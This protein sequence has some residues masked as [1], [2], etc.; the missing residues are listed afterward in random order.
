MIS[1]TKKI[2]LVSGANRGLGLSLARNLLDQNYVV[3]GVVRSVRA[4]AQILSYN[5]PEFLPIRTDLRDS[6]SADVICEFLG[7]HTAHLDLV[8]N[9][10]GH[11]ASTLNLSSIDFNEFQS[12][13]EIHC[14][15]PLKVISRVMPFLEAKKSVSS[16]INISSRFAS[17]QN[18]VSGAVPNEISSYAYRI[19]KSAQN[20][21]S[22][23]LYAEFGKKN[24][25]ILSVD[26]GK[27]KTRFGP[28]DADTDPDR[29]AKDIISLID[30]T[31]LNGVFVDRF[32]TVIPW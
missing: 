5:Q 11:G 2:A 15:A 32:G 27:L 20:M 14:E 12:V 18:V 19:A 24:I 8:I 21:M 7:E 23:C 29:A 30:N 31:E 26:P 13:F 1:G 16:V 10:A 28:Q 25:R 4:E 6:S 3:F 9:N 22:A 17:I